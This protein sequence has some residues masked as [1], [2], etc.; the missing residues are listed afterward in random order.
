[1]TVIDSVLKG[2]QDILALLVDERQDRSNLIIDDD[3]KEIT[4]VT[5]KT[6]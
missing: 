5:K 4:R 1:M 6:R 3:E 2:E